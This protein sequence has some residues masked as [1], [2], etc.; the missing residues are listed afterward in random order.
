LE[1]RPDKAR[2][3]AEHDA[4]VE[5]ETK[6]Y[7]KFNE[8]A[9]QGD[10]GGSHEEPRPVSPPAARASPSSPSSR[11]A[12]AMRAPSDRPPASMPGGVRESERRRRDPPVELAPDGLLLPPGSDAVPRSGAG[13]GSSQALAL[14]PT[15]HQLARAVGTGT[16]DA[17]QDIDEGEETALNAKKWK[18]ASFFNRVKRQVQ[19]HWRPNEAYQRR[20]PTGAVYG[21]KNR[22][23]VLRVQLKPDGSLANVALETPSGV[24]FLDDEAI[25]A[26]K[27]AQPFPN[28]P[29]QLVDEGGVIRFSFGFL[30][31][32]STSARG[33]IFRYDS[34]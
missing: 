32:L 16:Q 25:E 23:T 19:D 14:M 24:E 3:A 18:F 21:Q 4:T 10:P 29:R 9:H 28:P 31:E 22:L 12:L 17:L 11:S 33:R 13:G 7:G 6:R 27:Q 8:R 15:D 34:M 30:F 2:F 1:S 26:F 20:D 5:R